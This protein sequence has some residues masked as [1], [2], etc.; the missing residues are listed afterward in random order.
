[1]RVRLLGREENANILDERTSILSTLL[2]GNFI[3]L[4]NLN[5][6]SEMIIPSANP[7]MYELFYLLKHNNSPRSKSSI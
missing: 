6:W 3:V 7:K 4:S 1:M 2:L 5:C